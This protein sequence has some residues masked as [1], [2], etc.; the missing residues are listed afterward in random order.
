M[1]AKLQQDPNT[2]LVM[3]GDQGQPAIEKRRQ[4]RVREAQHG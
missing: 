4:R 3:L 1:K 2:K